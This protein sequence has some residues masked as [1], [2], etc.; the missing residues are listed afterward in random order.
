[1]QRLD[2]YNIPYP[3]LGWAG[4]GCS[5]PLVTPE[6]MTGGVAASAAQHCER[7]RG[8]IAVSDDAAAAGLL[9]H[10]PEDTRCLLLAWLSKQDM[11]SIIYASNHSSP[12][13]R[14]CV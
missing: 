12:C 7:L 4:L 1:M 6:G 5:P 11:V 14:T 13:V 10:V 9:S 8:L 3:G 2:A